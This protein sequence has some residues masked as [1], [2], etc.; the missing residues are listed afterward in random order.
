[1]EFGLL[2]AVV[3]AL[4]AAWS[5]IQVTVA[6]GQRRA[7]FDRILTAAVVGL[8]VGRT[9]AMVLAGTNPITHPVDLLII[10]GGVDT[11]LAATG[12]VLGFAWTARRDLWRLADDA[13]PAALTGLAGWHFGCLIGG[14][15]L[16]TPSTLPWA[17]SLSPGSVPRHPTEIYAAVALV[18]IAALIVA[19]RGRLTPTGV[20]ASLS[21][22]GAAAIRLAT[23]PLRLT[24]GDGPEKWY[25]AGLIVGIALTARRFVGRAP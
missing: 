18:G 15:C 16:G 25:L 23:E 13:G 7:T 24:I 12:A 5:M 20:I 4:G 9:G 10:R 3:L 17:W 11:G 2:A 22:A 1:M 6:P 14:S 8:F 21:L 19:L